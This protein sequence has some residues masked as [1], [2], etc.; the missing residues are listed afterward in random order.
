[1]KPCNQCGK[2]CINYSHGGLSATAQEVEYWELFRPDIARFVSNGEIWI[3]PDSGELLE[4][5]PWLNKADN[6]DVYSCDIYNDRP[7]DCKTYPI[8]IPQMIG[9]DC[10]MLEPEDV[11]KP[12]LGYSR[13]K[14]IM[15]DSWSSLQDN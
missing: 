13:L 2:C 3:D 9:D 12:K 6:A 4:L 11:T 7:D 5:C 10:E 1:M 15:S 14:L 8:N